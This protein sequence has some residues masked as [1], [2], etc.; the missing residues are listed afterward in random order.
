MSDSQRWLDEILALDAPNLIRVGL[1]VRGLKVKQAAQAVGL[2]PSRLSAALRGQRPLEEHVRSALM[3]LLGMGSLLV[4]RKPLVTV[5]GGVLSCDGLAFALEGPLEW[6]DVVRS[7]YPEIEQA[8]REESYRWVLSCPGLFLQLEPA[9]HRLSLSVA[10]LQIWPSRMT[11]AGWSRASWLIRSFEPDPRLTRVDV[12]VDYPVAREAIQLV[13]VNTHSGQ[14]LHRRSGRACPGGDW[15]VP[16]G[17]RPAVRSWHRKSTR[18]GSA[19]SDRHVRCYAH[20]ADAVEGQATVTRIEAQVG[21]RAGG[22]LSRL[23]ELPDPFAPIRVIVLAD[24][25]VPY[26]ESIILQDVRHFGTPYVRFRL[27]E[28]RWREFVAKFPLL[29]EVPG[30]RGPSELFAADW[31]RVVCELMARLGLGRSGAGVCLDEREALG[32]QGPATTALNVAED[33]AP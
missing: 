17:R 4:A 28:E 16:Y 6:V 21:G 2:S 3:D 25:A 1:A 22:R 5:P 18:V 33:V 8:G 26:P 14:I 29:D 15:V 10:N 32:D 30:Y 11:D 13:G 20:P 31:P 24:V 23:H 7:A 27:G 9:P 12:A 19:S